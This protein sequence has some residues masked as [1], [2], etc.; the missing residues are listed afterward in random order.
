MSTP[1]T[2]E[3]S[4]RETP[5]RCPVLYYDGEKEKYAKQATC[6]VLADNMGS[7]VGSVM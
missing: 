5:T 4:R 3:I 7:I 6:V 1:M 2:Q